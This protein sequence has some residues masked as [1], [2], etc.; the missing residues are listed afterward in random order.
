MRHSRFKSVAT[1]LLLA[2][3]GSGPLCASEVRAAPTALPPAH[4]SEGPKHSGEFSPPDESTIPDNELGRMVRLGERIF[5]N[6][7]IFAS[8]FVGNALRC[9]SCHLD[10]GRKA[11]SSPMWAAYVSY[12][13]YRAKS[14]RVV[15]FDERLQ[16]CFRYSMNGKAPPLGSSTLV[17]LDAYAHWLAT[18]AVVDPNLPGRGYPSIGKAT[19]SDFNRG[20]TIYAE[21]CALCH[22]A[23]GAG[24]TASNGTA[25]FPA[26]WGP[27]SFNW[28][29]GMGNVTNAATFI[30]ANMPLGQGGT[31][32]DQDAWDVA[33]YMDSH[34][35][36]Q[37]PRYTGS[38]AETRARFHAGSDWMYG[39]SVNGHVLGSDSPP[40]GL[41]PRR[42]CGQNT[43][44]C[45]SREQ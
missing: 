8:P 15:T 38:V 25:A 5:E 31:L 11:G 4:S 41:H 33:L 36:P 12:P 14:H 42:Q 32:G 45:D 35:R 27:G 16:D 18:G 20:K 3:V 26:L 34:E 30:K 23:D 22:G 21:R 13:T 28:G 7:T 40:A 1:L 17:A 19:G 43:S 37:D 10:A 39:Q 24:Q 9:S 44:N 2:G 29:A 6:P